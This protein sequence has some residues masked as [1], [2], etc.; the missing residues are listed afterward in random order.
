MPPPTLQLFMHL[1]EENTT[2]QSEEWVSRTACG[3]VRVA[4]IQTSQSPNERIME[5]SGEIFVVQESGVGA[6]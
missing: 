5:D 3:Y 2:Q 1:K 4:R 6:V